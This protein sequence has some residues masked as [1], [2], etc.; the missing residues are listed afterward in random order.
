MTSTTRGP[1]RPTLGPGHRRTTVFLPDEQITDL[2]RLG[3]GSASAGIRALVEDR[4][5]LAAALTRACA[6]LLSTDRAEGDTSTAAELAR[7]YVEIART[8]AA[9]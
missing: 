3:G 7:E 4:D 1:G 9:G 2:Q 6:D 8:E 5:L